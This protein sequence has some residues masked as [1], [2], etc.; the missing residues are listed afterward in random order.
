MKKCLILTL[1]SVVA[2]IATATTVHATPV[3]KKV[4]EEV[5]VGDDAPEEFAAAV[6][7]AKCNVCHAGKKKADRN[8]Y[9]AELAKL[10]DKDNFKTSRMKAE[11]EA[12]D[13]I[14]EAYK[15]VGAVDCGNGGTWDEAFKAGNLPKDEV[16]SSDDDE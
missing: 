3:F 9:G 14:I 4:W 5:Y 1:S 16:V 10:L 7:E 2:M 15:K 12:K 13:E 6:K 11:P 8:A